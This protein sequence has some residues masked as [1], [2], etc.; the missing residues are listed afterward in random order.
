MKQWVL[1]EQVSPDLVRQILFYRG[2]KTEEEIEKFLNPDYE[3]DLHD[4]L[5]ILNMDKAVERILQAIKNNERIIIFGD[6]D[7][8]G[9]C[10]S[11]IFYDFFK[12]I[13]FENFHIHIP[14]RHLGG[15]GLTK[16][17][18]DEFVGQK[19]NLIITLD[20][21]ITDYEEIEKAKSKRID[22]III[23]HH[24]VPEKPPNALAI[25]DLKQKGENYPFKEFCGAGLTFK[26]IKALIK[27]G[28]F[29]IVPGWEKW[30]LDLVAIA[31]VADMV[32][33]LEENRTLV[34]FGL[35][36][37]KKTKRQGLLLFFRRFEINPANIT[38][39]D[40]AFVIAPRINLASRMGHAN[41]SF[42]LLTTESFNE[43]T[44]ITSHLEMLNNERKSIVEEILKE[45]EEEINYSGIAEIIVYG[46]INWS[47]GVL[48]IGATRLVEK[49]HCPV[50][51]WGKGEAKEIKGS[52]RSDGSVNLVELMQK[53]PNDFFIDAGGHFMAAGFSLKEDKIDDFKRELLLAFKKVSKQKVENEILYIDK[54]ISLDDIDWSLYSL[55]EKLQP[56]GIGNP[57]PLFLLSN[58]EIA[59]MRKFGNGGIHLQLDFKKS[60]PVGGEEII[61]AI[62]FFSNNND[63][64]LQSGQK[65]D[66]VASLEKSF[67]RPIPELRLRIVDINLRTN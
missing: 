42:D 60:L 5:L 28:Q 19:A 15:Y 49:Y 55:I 23:D 11:V 37:F 58:L 9:V 50:F 61:S 57:K 65:I 21:G 47:P 46:N 48:S 16:E 30:L 22:V 25:I 8:D 4:S 31:T 36:V 24:L 17:A 59:N 64:R 26:T 18:I 1:R 53:M 44:W 10:A 54:E 51:L 12:K 6:Y 63:Y 67:F 27:K 32:P 66:I 62:N 3:R 41:T 2:I 33:I 56:F 29:K 34:Y 39:D 13:G 7:A 38:E 14:D 20:C 52:A 40:I 35:R 45:I 43:A